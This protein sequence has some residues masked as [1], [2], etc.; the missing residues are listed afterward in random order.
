MLFWKNFVCAQSIAARAVRRARISAAALALAFSALVS[1]APFSA[2]ADTYRGALSFSALSNGNQSRSYGYVADD[3]NLY[4]N[5]G[6]NGSVTRVTYTGA[7]LTFN[8]SSQTP[9]SIFEHTTFD[10]G[11][12]LAPCFYYSGCT[13]MV[14][15]DYYTRPR[16]DVSL[17]IPGGPTSSASAPYGGEDLSTNISYIHPPQYAPGD[18]RGNYLF[19]ITEN[20]HSVKSGGDFSITVDLSR[21][22]F[23]RDPKLAQFYLL[24]DSSSNFSNL[25]TLNSIQAVIQYDN[26]PPP[27]FYLPPGYVLPGS[28]P[29]PAT[30][31]LMIAGFGLAGAALR[32]QRAT[33]A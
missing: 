16:V 20:T 19:Q 2:H 30:W 21:D 6:I 1:W 27:G 15:D 12:S 11:A 7:S 31:A 29:E 32:R 28:V 13:S 9:D 17:S 10:G 18:P 4:L 26:I 22:Y 33:A 25:V 8:F 5:E 24:F 14:V 3:P 23:I